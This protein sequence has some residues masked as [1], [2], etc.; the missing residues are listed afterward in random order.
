[1]RCVALLVLAL[2]QLDRGWTVA[3]TPPR[4]TPPGKAAGWSVRVDERPELDL[5]FRRQLPSTTPP[6][7]QLV[8][9]FYASN[10]SV[11][12]EQQRIYQFD[13]ERVHDRMTIHVVALP[14]DAAGKTLYVRVQHPRGDPYFG[15]APWLAARDEL[16]AAMHAIAIT[17]LREDLGDMIAGAILFVIGLVALLASSV[18]RRGDTRT[19][20]WFG[21][22]SAL[23]GARLLADSHL[24]FALGMRAQLMLYASAWITYMINLPG[25]ALARRLIGGGWKSTLRWQLAIFMIFAPVGIASDL[26]SGRPQSLELVNNVLVILGGVNIIINLVLLQYNVLL[27]EKRWWPAELR[28]VLAGSL[29][30]TLLALGNNLSPL[31]LLPWGDTGEHIGFIIFVLALG[32]AATRE[33]LRGERARVALENEMATAREIQQSILPATMPDVAGLRFHALYDPASSV[34]GDL[35]DVLRVDEQRAGAIVADVSGH[36]V[37]AALV[38]SMMKIAVSSQAP[39]AHDPPALLRAVSRTLRGQ[40]KRVFVTATYLFFDMEQRRVDVANAGHPSPLLHRDGDVRE[41]GGQGVVLGRF[42][43]P[44]T[45]ESIEL[46]VHDRIVAYT[47]GVTEALNAKGEAFGEERLHAMIRDGAGAD[48]IARAVRQ[49]R[50][51]KTEADDVTLLIIQVSS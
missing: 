14:A 19:L 41:I 26:I 12:V 18:I 13:D 39:L 17:P 48:D 46:R 5:W 16:P 24:P 8:F 2:V 23:Y 7:A 50:D 35:Y 47:D 34:A 40:V 28:V 4:A 32:F 44:Y 9:R 21:L 11:F 36:G 33:F 25:W 22:M 10:V 42:D 37:P 20:L 43:A 27:R 1:V 31:G 49:W 29:I 15:G 6:D 51:P 30:F 3:V 45:A 38:A